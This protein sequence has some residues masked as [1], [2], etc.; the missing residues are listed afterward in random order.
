MEVGLI[1]T[2]LLAHVM[3]HDIT[4]IIEGVSRHSEIGIMK[5]R[6]L[7]V[8]DE[9]PALTR[10]VELLEKQSDVEIVGLARHGREAIQLIRSQSP[11]LRFLDIQTPGMSAFEV[12]SEIAPEQEPLTIFVTGYD[13]YAIPAFEAQ[14]FD[15]L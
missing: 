1:P 10:M 13:K 4:H 15:Y 3:V 14:A 11:D 9:K 2:E 12:L 6:A 7:V 5:I 8:D